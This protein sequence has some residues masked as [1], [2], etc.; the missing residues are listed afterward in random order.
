MVVEEPCSV[1]SEES[2]ACDTSEQNCAERLTILFN[3]NAGQML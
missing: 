1:H 3:D 2:V